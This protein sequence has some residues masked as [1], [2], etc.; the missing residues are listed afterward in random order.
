MGEFS[1][2][3]SHSTANYVEKRAS[4]RS[5]SAYSD[6]YNANKLQPSASK[7][8][9]LIRLMELVLDPLIIV[10]S[11]WL[12]CLVFSVPFDTKYLI[13]STI[14]F[15]ISFM[16]FKEMAVCRS[17][18]S[19]GVKAQTR[20]TLLGWV[21]VIAILMAIAYMTKTSSYF[22]RTVIITWCLVTPPVLIFGHWVVRTLLFN[23]AKTDHFN[24]NVVIVGINEISN[25]LSHEINTDLRLNLSLSGYFD[26]RRRHE[27]NNIKEED[28]LGGLKDLPEYVKQNNID[29][30]YV[31]LPMTQQ[32]RILNLLDE[33]HDTT[34]SVYFV[35]DLFMFDL[36]QARLDDVNGLPVVAVCE[37]PFYGVN[38]VLKRISDIV[39]AIIIFI[40]LIPILI[41]I[42]VA[43]RIDSPGKA[44][45]KQRRYGLDGQEITVYKFRSMTVTENN[46]VIVQATQDDVRVT[47][48]GGFLRRYSLDELP[49]FFNVIQGR[50]S[51][52]GPRPH[53]VAHNESYR[54]LV[55]GYMV[56]HKVKPGITGWAQVSGCRGETDSVEKMQRRIEYDLEY[57]RNWSLWFDTKIIFK[58]V[59]TIFN[60]PNAY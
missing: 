8:L 18:R 29:V 15:L 27:Y 55:K 39:F 41:C 45:F 58:T 19:G 22:S 36:I 53:A 13:F 24:R 30:I 26:D 7:P 42:A 38:G 6:S 10:L 17:W 11:I 3:D 43:V 34:A 25:K 14:A 1:G 16:V 35:P 49:Q 32:A 40:L 48:V 5:S 12:T 28:I 37:T 44:I 20:N 21:I 60:D 57:L 23:F 51:I 47:K 46:E 59:F 52:V 31:A 9:T 56:R 2:S 4:R 54:K 50:M 33:L